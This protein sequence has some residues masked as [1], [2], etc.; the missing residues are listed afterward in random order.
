MR[1]VL[2]MGGG[3]GAAPRRLLPRG[4]GARQPVRGDARAG[5]RGASAGGLELPRH[6]R[7]P[8]NL[9]GA[10]RRLHGHRASGRGGSRL[11]RR[12]DPLLPRCGAAAGRG[13]PA[14]RLA[15]G[16]GG[17][18]D[19]ESGGAAGEFHRLHPR[20]PAPGAAERSDREAADHGTRRTRAVHRAGGCR[21]RQG[22]GRR[23][24]RPH[25]LR[26]TGLQRPQPLL[27]DGFGIGGLHRV[28]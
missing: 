26:R 12:A 9:H 7:D 3:G 14:V 22:G 18:A 23:G 25:A 8:Q 16:R 2:R 5:R 28:R 6:S 4:A 13:Q 24:H 1:R 20:R 27:R 21:H 17:A 19:G 10:R 15:R 11:R